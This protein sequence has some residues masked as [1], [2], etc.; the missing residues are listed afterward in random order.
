LRK[1]RSEEDCNFYRTVRNG[2]KARRKIATIAKIA[3]IAKI[4]TRAASRERVLQRVLFKR[5]LPKTKECQ[6]SAVGSKLKCPVF[7]ANEMSGL[8]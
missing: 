5:V 7:V 1:Q 6:K 3:G 4:E 8:G 2:R